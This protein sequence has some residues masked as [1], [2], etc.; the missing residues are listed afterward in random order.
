MRSRTVAIW[1]GVVGGVALIAKVVVMAVQGGP[2]PA[3]SVPES[4][5]FFAGMIG[6]IVAAAAAGVH[7]TRGR[8]VVWRALAAIAGVAVVA[9]ALGLGQAI[10][11]ALPGDSWWQE[12]SIF[13]ILG[14]VALASA[15]KAARVTPSSV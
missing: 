5:A 10:L 6:L 3:T 1:A 8:T 9:L 4:I 12:E 15:G 11:S 2:E 7:F 14:L 13:G